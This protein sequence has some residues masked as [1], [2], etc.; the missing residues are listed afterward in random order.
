MKRALCSLISVL[1]LL[2]FTAAASV[3]EQPDWIPERLRVPPGHEVLLRALAAGVQ[4]YDCQASSGDFQWVFRTPEAGL[5]H[6]NIEL[7][8]THYAGP[9]W[10]ARDGSRVVGMR[11]DSIDAPNPSSIPWLLL[12]A[13]SHEGSGTF[14]G[15]T[16][17]QRVLT[18]GGVAPPPCTCDASHVGDEAR[19]EYI[20]VYYFYVEASVEKK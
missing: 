5:F 13:A 19:V 2:P 17:I 15:V 20:A 14:S 9:T 16:Y 8:G 6:G 10:Q 7:I 18:G 1:F 4:I 12:R 11:V 3:L